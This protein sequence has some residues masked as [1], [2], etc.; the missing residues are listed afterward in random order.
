MVKHQQLSVI[1]GDEEMNRQSTED[2]YSSEDTQCG[3][4]MVNSY[5]YTIVQTH[6]MHSSESDP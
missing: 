2:F 3:T 6:G 5:N 4:I 1:R